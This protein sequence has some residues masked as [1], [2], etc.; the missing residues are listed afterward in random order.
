M[1]LTIDIGNTR[2]KIC[3]FDDTACI[4]TFDE[5]VSLTHTLEEIFKNH[6]IDA[7][8]VSC[9]GRERKHLEEMLKRQTDCV[10]FVDGNTPGPIE[11]AYSGRN[12]LG[13]DRWAAAV[14][15]ATLKPNTDLLII[16]AGTCITYDLVSSNGR[17]L[18]GNI[19]PG[20]EMRFQALH[21]HTAR[22]PKLTSE[23][24]TPLWGTDT[25]SAIRTGVMR[26]VQHE[27]EGFISEFTDIY[28]QLFIF[29][30][31]GTPFCFPERLKSRIFAQPNLVS[32]GLNVLLRHHHKG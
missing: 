20:I 25:A 10:L 9:V 3:L 12:T 2:A 21:E 23:G 17:Y 11:N 6:A 30:T 4:N 1:N 13:A 19:S 24:E 15:A 32:I 26:G 28:A 5:G 22:L 8:A 29:L 18:G 31:G 16:D 14:G 27:I 7:C